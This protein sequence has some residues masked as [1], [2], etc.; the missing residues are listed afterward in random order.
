V[1]ARKTGFSSY[2]GMLVSLD[3]FYQMD[4]NLAMVQ[5]RAPIEGFHILSGGLK[6]GSSRSYGLRRE[7]VIEILS[8]G[9]KAFLSVFCLIL[10]VLED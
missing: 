6:S 10:S 4:S 3:D 1:A 5:V 7:G 2:P 9:V 8:R